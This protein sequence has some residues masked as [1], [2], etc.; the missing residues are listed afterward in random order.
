[1]IYETCWRSWAVARRASTGCASRGA[2]ST[3][4]GAAR[5]PP[6]GTAVNAKIDS[7]GSVPLTFH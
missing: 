3:P 7:K 1:M 4:G 2:G 6:R 5:G